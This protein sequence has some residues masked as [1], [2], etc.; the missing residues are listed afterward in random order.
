MSK[1]SYD[2]HVRLIGLLPLGF[3]FSKDENA[4]IRYK[5][6]NLKKIKKPSEDDHEG[7]VAISD[8]KTLEATAI[9]ETKTIRHSVPQAHSSGASSITS[10][11]V[12]KLKIDKGTDVKMVQKLCGPDDE[13]SAPSTSHQQSLETKHIRH[14]VPVSPAHVSGS[15]S[16]ASKMVDKQK[17]QEDTNVKTTQELRK[18]D[19]EPT[20]ASTSAQVTDPMNEDESAKF[21]C[22]SYF[23]M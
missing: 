17:I 2:Y 5:T 20:E 9:A 8:K 19:D 14:S 3:D 18:P 11:M 23:N 21:L 4:G 12:D 6:D 7:E 10:E 1:I 16:I 15:S 13:S 22:K